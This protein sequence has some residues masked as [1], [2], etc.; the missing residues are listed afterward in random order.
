MDDHLNAQDAHP[1]PPEPLLWTRPEA[2]RRLRVSVR[3][4][5]ALSSRGELRQVRIGRTV[6]YPEE[7]LRR[8]VRERSRPAGP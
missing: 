6:R 5:D 7:E 2:A 4:L 1:V 3:T 8:F